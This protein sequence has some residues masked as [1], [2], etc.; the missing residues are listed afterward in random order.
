MMRTLP[1]HWTAHRHAWFNKLPLKVLLS[2]RRHEL[3]RSSGASLAKAIETL[4]ADV[5]S[6]GP[7]F[8]ERRAAAAAGLITLGA[9]NEFA[10]L[11][12]QNK[13]LSI[14]LGRYRLETV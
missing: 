1:A 13:P 10:N 14:H 5:M 9:M 2:I 8:E 6:L 3:L 12:E 4:L 7:D 11:C